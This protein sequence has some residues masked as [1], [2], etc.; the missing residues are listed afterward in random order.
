MKR[1][2][3]PRPVL[4]HQPPPRP[5]ETTRLSFNVATKPRPDPKPG[6]AQPRSSQTPSAAPQ[7]PAPRYY[8]IP[9]D[10]RWKQVLWAAHQLQGKNVA[11]IVNEALAAHFKLPPEELLRLQSDPKWEPRPDREPTEANPT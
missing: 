6:K 9:V 8:K 11:A 7:T 4:D 3:G 5:A 2:H 1:H 10:R